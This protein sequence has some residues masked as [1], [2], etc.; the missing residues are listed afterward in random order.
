MASFNPFFFI[1]TALLISPAYSL[2]CTS[3]TFTQGNPR[4][5][6]CT[7]LP[8]LKAYLHWTYDPTAMPKPTLSVAFIAPP[9]KSDG[10]IAWALNPTGMGMVGSQ[11]LVAFKDSNG[12][13]V[14]KTYNISSYNSIV[15]SKIFYDVLEK[16]AEFSSGAMRI[17]AK[18]AL[19]SDATELNQVWQVGS[20]VRN[21]M[22]ENHDLG[23][24]NLNAKGRLSL[25]GEATAS[26]PSQAP[27]L[28]PTAGSGNGRQNGNANG[29]SR[30]EVYGALVLLL[31]IP[32]IHWF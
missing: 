17:F 23:S 16:K 4:F 9:A 19:P 15:E 11:A 25:G 14:V 7:D 10:W 12:S 6:N 24:D 26:T 27:A 1:A 28:S 3:Q 30:I 13:M 5:T 8:V 2:T 18:L 22:P 21:G 32:L 29:S 20:A 31:V